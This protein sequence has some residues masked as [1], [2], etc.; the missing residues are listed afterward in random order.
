MLNHT[1][2]LLLCSVATLSAQE[3][4]LTTGISDIQGEAGS[5]SFSLG[6]VATSMAVSTTYNMV[7]GVQQPYDIV[8]LAL[9]PMASPT[10]MVFPN[11]TTDKVIVSMEAP[12]PITAILYDNAGRRLRTLSDTKGTNMNV[13]MD[14]LPA[15][16][17]LLE[18]TPKDGDRVSFKIIK[19]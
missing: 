9:D 16:I 4:L 6:Q 14:G 13:P 10:C 11:P 15:G 12:T 5:I 18:V 8:M 3:A 19:K 1:V 17:Y 2:V 7:E